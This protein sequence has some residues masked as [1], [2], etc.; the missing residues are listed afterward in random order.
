MIVSDRAEI[1][2][3]TTTPKES[4]LDYLLQIVILIILPEVSSPEKEEMIF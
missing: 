2:Q 3:G 1:I 4:F